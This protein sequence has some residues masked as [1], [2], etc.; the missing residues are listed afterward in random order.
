MLSG[1]SD[2]VSSHPLWMP[3]RLTKD[4]AICYFYNLSAATRYSIP[5][6]WEF[7]KSPKTCQGCGAPRPATWCD[8]C[9]RIV[10]R[11]AE[12]T[13]CSGPIRDSSWEPLQ[14]YMKPIAALYMIDVGVMER[15]ALANG[16]ED[17]RNAREFLATS[18]ESLGEPIASPPS[19]QP[20]R[21][22]GVGVPGDEPP[23]GR[24]GYLAGGIEE[25]WRAEYAF[26]RFGKSVLKGYWVTQRWMSST[27][28]CTVRKGC[29][30]ADNQIIHPTCGRAVPSKHK[31][32]ASLRESILSMQFQLNEDEIYSGFYP[33]LP[34]E[35]VAHF[36]PTRQGMERFR[37]GEVLYGQPDE[38]GHRHPVRGG[39]EITKGRREHREATKDLMHVGSGLFADLAKNKKRFAEKRKRDIADRGQ[40]IIYRMPDVPG[41]LIVLLGVMACLLASSVA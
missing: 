20:P 37:G 28:D 8:Y 30:H 14:R 35:D 18:R 2:S 34:G 38:K 22:V 25:V 23:S 32:F 7:A 27:C 15:M 39:K 16:A 29:V 13:L 17:T 41:E 40:R 4:E 6:E 11:T 5:Q 19:L 10:G 36:D 33:S 24:V 1:N 31:D 3:L 12:E 21:W 26:D 9:G